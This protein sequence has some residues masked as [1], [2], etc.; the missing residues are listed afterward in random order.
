MEEVE[1]MDKKLSEI[2]KLKG[3]KIQGFLAIAEKQRGMV[4]MKMGDYKQ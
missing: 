2:D 1:I 4:Y 3:N